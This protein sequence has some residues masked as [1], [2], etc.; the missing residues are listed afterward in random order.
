MYDKNKT[1]LVGVYQSEFTSK[2]E[3]EKNNAGVDV[4]KVVKYGNITIN[5]KGIIITLKPALTTE[6]LAEAE[7]ISKMMFKAVT[8]EMDLKK[9]ALTGELVAKLQSI[10]LA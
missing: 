4:P 9:N 10:K 1:Y 6:F 8:V 3:T 5:Q 2:T 7:E